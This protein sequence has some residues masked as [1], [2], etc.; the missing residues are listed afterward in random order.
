[1]A[2]KESY[3]LEVWVKFDSEET[4]EGREIKKFLEERY[5]S[6]IPP[7]PNQKI[8]FSPHEDNK[9]K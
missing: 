2:G 1:M 3:K 6:K 4:N 8:I 9:K 7:I 5:I